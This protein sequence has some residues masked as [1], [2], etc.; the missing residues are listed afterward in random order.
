MDTTKDYVFLSYSHKDDIS[1]LLDYFEANG[2]NVVYDAELSAGEI[3]DMKVRRYISSIKCKGVLSVLSRSS[4]SSPAILKEIDYVRLFNKKL[5]SIALDNCSPAETFAL[6]S[7]EDE[8]EIAKA[9]IDSF[10]PEKIY[11]TQKELLSGESDKLDKTLRQWGVY[12]EDKT[13]ESEFT[14][15]DRYTSKLEGEVDRL[16]HQQLGYYNF[17]MDAINSVLADCDRK[18]LVVLDLGCSNGESTASRFADDRFGLV[19]GVDYNA[20][21]IEKA[22]NAHYGDKFHFFVLDL[23]C[24]EL[25]DDLP[26]NLHKLGVEKVDVVFMALTLHHLKEPN[27][28][29]FRLYDVFDEDG[30]IIIRGSDDGGKLSYPESELMQE[31]FTRYNALVHSVTD[32]CNGRKLY[33]QLLDAGYLNIKMQYQVTDT[34]EKSRAEKVNFYRVGF[35]FREV[36]LREIADRNPQNQ[37]IQKEVEWQLKT[38]AHIKE[39][40]GHRDFWYSNVSYIATATVR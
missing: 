4:L 40:F 38:L 2:Y 19:I 37:E 12:V 11:V 10:P 6:L 7:D 31:L 22:E 39:M 30:R 17:D 16:H 29:L 5:A 33:K 25:I 34:C 24:D 18:N 23:E 27:K 20:Q 36:R 21:D 8:Q 1:S 13:S 35:G 15:I 3:W 28:L 9:I 14:P 26:R 32:R